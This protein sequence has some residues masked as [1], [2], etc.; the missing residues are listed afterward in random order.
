[1]DSL[2]FWFY[3]LLTPTM[4]W[5]QGVTKNGLT[6]TNSDNFVDKNGQ[7]RSTIS[8][9]KNG[10]DS[11]ITDIDGNVY[12]IITIGTQTW[13][14]SNLKTSHYRDGTIIPNVV[15]NNEWTA[16]I[17]DATC[18]MNNSA[19]NDAIYGKFYNWYAAVN[20]H[21]IAPVGW[22]VPTKNEFVT[23]ANFLNT[24][25]GSLSAKATASTK[26]WTVVKA[27]PSNNMVGVNQYQNN[28]SGFNVTCGG[29]R[30]SSGVFNLNG[31]SSYLL[32]STSTMDVD[33]QLC[34]PFSIYVTDKTLSTNY[35]LYSPIQAFPIR[36]IKDI[37]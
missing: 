26:N 33:T 12:P 30:T 10:V 6:A 7:I 29:Y 23:L 22:H 18:S 16:L 28:S 34:V 25:Y 1:M 19:S 4:L 24:K 35:N 15:D 37:P 9:K 11:T 13:M 21:N 20:T 2:F 3:L 8:L 14:A 32:T 5:S 27:R 31:L 36:C 17:N